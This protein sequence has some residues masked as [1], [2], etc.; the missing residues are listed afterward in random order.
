MVAASKVA[1]RTLLASAA[2]VVSKSSIA[3]DSSSAVTAVEAWCNQTRTAQAGRLSALEQLLSTAQSSGSSQQGRQQAG[4]V[5]QLAEQL[6]EKTMV[7][8]AVKSAQNQSLSA[9]QLEVTDAAREIEVLSKTLKTLGSGDSAQLI[10]KLLKAA[11]AAKEQHDKA[12]LLQ[13]NALEAASSEA[14]H[15]ESEYNSSKAALEQQE[16]QE[17]TTGRSLKVLTAALED[18]AAYFAGVKSLCSTAAHVSQ[19]LS[20]EIIPELEQEQQ[21]QLQREQQHKKEEQAAA[22]ATTVASENPAVKPVVKPVEAPVAKE[23]KV[24]AKPAVEEAPVTQAVAA[25]AADDKTA[26]D[27]KAVEQEAAVA[28][29]AKQKVEPEPVAAE[30]PPAADEDAADSAESTPASPIALVTKTSAAPPAPVTPAVATKIAPVTKKKT[31]AKPEEPKVSSETSAPQQKNVAKKEAVVT[32]TALPVSEMPSEYSAWRPDGAAPAKHD[33]VDLKPGESAKDKMMALLGGDDDA[34]TPAVVLAK[35][36]SKDKAVKTVS[37]HHKA[38]PAPPPAAPATDDVVADD[39]DGA[40]EKAA[41]ESPPLKAKPEAVEPVQA[42]EPEPEATIPAV[43]LAATDAKPS[44]PAA[45]AATDTD[46]LDE[47]ASASTATTEAPAE[48]AV[49]VTTAAPAV[50]V[51]ADEAVDQAFPGPTD[52]D[53]DS[54]PAPPR[55]HQGVL[56]QE[57]KHPKKHSKQKK[58]APVAEQP[59]DSPAAVPNAYSAWTPTDDDKPKKDA[60]LEAMMSDFETDEDEAPKPVV[61]K[62]K[63]H[64]HKQKKAKKVSKKKAKTDDDDDNDDNVVY[65]DDDLP[66]K[67]TH[68]VPLAT[69]MSGGWESL[70]RQKKKT[71]KPRVDADV[72]IM[73]DLYANGGALPN[74]YAAWKPEDDEKKAAAAAAAATTAA[75]VELSAD[76]SDQDSDDSGNVDDDLTKAAAKLKEGDG[77]D[78][79]ASFV[80]LSAIH[81]HVTSVKKA[82]GGALRGSRQ[83]SVS[84]VDTAT[85][86]LKTFAEALDSS[87]LKTVAQVPLTAE[88]LSDVSKTLKDSAAKDSGAKQSKKQ[89]RAQKWCSY[90]QKHAATSTPL[91]KAVGEAEAAA[92]LVSEAVVARN[93]LQEEADARSQLQRTVAQDVQGLMQLLA[94]EKEMVNST[95]ALPSSA[96]AKALEDAHRELADVIEGVWSQ[97]STVVEDQTSKLTQLISATKDA[98]ADVSTKKAN[99]DKTQAKL[100]AARNKLKGIRTSCDSALLSLARRQ[101]HN[102]AEVKAAEQVLKVLQGNV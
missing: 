20:D 73:E 65:D 1:L 92:E 101:H 3:S 64:T 97:R 23:T 81:Q 75:P 74:Q 100:D 94:I 4:N 77:D 7:A 76:D 18:E 46:L 12:Q 79:G 11:Q 45:S 95:G 42:P 48:L 15:L 99:A 30:T 82:E 69:E 68:R 102:R 41:V 22:T 84:R 24:D 98:D 61:K 33:E 5:T 31:G 14:M 8:E 27:E 6:E 90:F 78:D 39:S 85:V 91:K 59:S 54:T 9:A 35:V 37:K 13:T 21:N 88:K 29:D 87:A 36:S 34:S 63:H 66:M 53:S 72:A 93:A 38:T 25:V 70:M 43:E 32:T 80:Q 86:L 49:D 19:R 51:D 57:K 26:A 96:S 40:I 52:T 58:V 17:S 16:H 47:T 83:S 67:K 2:F 44:P 50:A 71:T 62:Q 55:H 10:Q 28:A 56:V 60:S 89:V